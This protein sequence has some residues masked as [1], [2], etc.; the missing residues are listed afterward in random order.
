MPFLAVLLSTLREA[1]QPRRLAVT[2]LLVFL[3]AI[4]G[5]GWKLIAGAE[6]FD[7]PEIYN[8][9][10]AVLVFGF[11]L[12]I[13]SVLYG[14]GALSQEI[15]GR[16]IVYLL[17]RPMPRW[18]ILLAKFAGAWVAITVTTCLSLLLLGVAVFGG[19]LPATF[20]Q[21]LRI[22]PLGAL[23]YAG[24]FL[25]VATLL[26]RPL[27][28]GLFFAFL[29]ESWVPLLPG[30][31]ARL[32]IMAYLRTLAPHL[33]ETAETTGA[34]EG[35]R[36]AVSLLTSFTPTEI[37]TSHAWI[38]LAGIIVATVTLAMVFFSTREYAPREEG[39]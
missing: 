29:W 23:A 30:G 25:M 4:I 31:F 10:A 2:F 28:F 17:T 12:T 26:S 21:D 13:L 15:E 19:K 37:P 6:R 5:L 33:K 34:E 39:G 38:T 9:L 1:A 7:A 18:Q 20:F 36:N 14:T 27:I 22:L 32:S 3:P 8:T 24:L 35:Q 16:T 11:I